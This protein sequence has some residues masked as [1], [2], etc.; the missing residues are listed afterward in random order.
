ME[1]YGD[2]A[3]DLRDSIALQQLQAWIYPRIEELP[4]AQ[5]PSRL[6]CGIE[7]NAVSLCH[8]LSRARLVRTPNAR[9]SRAFSAGLKPVV[10]QRS[11]QRSQP[12]SGAGQSLWAERAPQ[13]QPLRDEDCAI[14][15]VPRFPERHCAQFPFEAT[16]CSAEVARGP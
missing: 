13:P 3:R 5:P 6:A 7:Q 16:S 15:H 14:R 8:L 4:N 11:H 12:A 2:G 1:L 9:V 10:S